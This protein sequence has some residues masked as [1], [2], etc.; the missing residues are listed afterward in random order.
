MRLEVACIS[1]GTATVRLS[2]VKVILAEVEPT[3]NLIKKV[4]CVFNAFNRVVWDGFYQEMSPDMCRSRLFMVHQVRQN[5][6]FQK[7]AV[8]DSATISCFSGPP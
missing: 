6:I 8:L 3:A 1:A 4:V 2:A 7:I 5:A